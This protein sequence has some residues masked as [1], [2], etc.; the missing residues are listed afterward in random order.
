MR[1]VKIVLGS[2]G[3]FL[4][5]ALGWTVGAAE[6]ANLNLQE[7]IRDLAAQGGAQIGL[8][9]PRTDEDVRSTVVRKAQEH[10]IPLKPQQVMVQ[11]TGSGEASTLRVAA[12]YTVPVNFWLFSVNLHFAPS[13]DKSGL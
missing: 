4:A 11:R 2:A 12:Q 8:L 10:G 3:L 13:S 7:D 6:V 9:A 1:M 5:I